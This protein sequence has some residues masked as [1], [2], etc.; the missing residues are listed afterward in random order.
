LFIYKWPQIDA[1]K[2]PETNSADTEIP[3]TYL[4]QEQVS[5]YLGVK[6]FKR[7]YPG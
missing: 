7:K 5:E 3:D 2:K 6:S 4:L 1:K